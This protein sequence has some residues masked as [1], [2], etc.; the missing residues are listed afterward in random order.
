MEL[1]NTEDGIV[2]PLEY[3]LLIHPFSDIW[4]RDLTTKKDVASVEFAYIEFLC[5]YAKKNPYVGYDDDIKESKVRANAAR[6]I[7]GWQPDEL[8]NEGVAIY[9]SFRDE[10]SPTL[11]FY[12]SN[13]EGA[14]R[15]QDY[16]KTVDLTKVTKTGMLVNKPSDVAR[17]LSQASAIMTNLEALKVK[18]QQE[19]F[20]SNKVR[21]NR[22]VNHFER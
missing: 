3:T 4:N 11:R 20:E 6:T 10:A 17:S 16:F 1:F 19:L 15:L 7:N 2:T 5:S 21:A 12:L 14:K 9:C 18:V 22:I 13:L 8:V